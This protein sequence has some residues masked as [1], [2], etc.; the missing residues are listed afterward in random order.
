MLPHKAADQVAA[1][2][3]VSALDIMSISSGP[4]ILPS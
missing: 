1:A 3:E 4:I 2:T